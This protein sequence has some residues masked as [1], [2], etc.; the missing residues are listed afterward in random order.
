VTDPRNLLISEQ[1]LD[2]AQVLLAQHTRGEAAGV[3]D[4]ELW[5]AKRIKDAII[6]PVTGEKMFLPGRMSAFLPMNAIPTAGMLLARTPAA[7]IFFQWMNQTVNTMANYVNRSGA[8]IDTTQIAQAY[9]LGCGVSCGIAVGAG[10]L[11]QSGPPW[12]KRLGVAVPYAAVVASGGVNVAFTRMPEIHQ[13]APIADREGNH[14]GHSRSAAV[15]SVAMAI[16][17]RSVVL[18]IAPMLFP[19]LAM[20]GLR[21]MLP[22]LTGIAA[23][24]AEVALVASSIYVALPVAIGA[25][26]QNIEIPTSALEP[27]FHNLK[28]S[29][30]RPITHIVCNR[31]L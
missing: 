4:H 28:D 16:A 12:V 11:V 13:G 27:E 1:E 14:L 26:P 5:E 9:A 31:G 23:V 6:H 20:A 8:S 10:R 19:P 30:G 29:N 7:T 21:A 18:P 17:S 3:S 15:T 24:A 25:F 2:N 22:S